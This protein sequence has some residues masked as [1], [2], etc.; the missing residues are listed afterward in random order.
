[1]DNPPSV[2]VSHAS[3]DK[4]RFVRGFA[5][6]LRDN[7]VD[8]WFDEWEIG[9]GD[10]LV[11]KIQE[12]IQGAPVGIAVLSRNSVTKP[13]VL[14]ELDALIVR[15]VAG[16]CRIIPIVLEDC[17]VP[18]LLRATHYIRIRNTAD[19]SE[20]LKQ[21]LHSLFGISNRPGI[22]APPPFADEGH[23]PINGLTRVDSIVLKYTCDAVLNERDLHIREEELLDH[24]R[25]LGIPDNEVSD[26]IVVLSEQGLIHL[27]A[28]EG[29]PHINGGHRWFE[30]TLHGFDM[31]ANAYVP[32]YQDA[33]AGVMGLIANEG[34]TQYNQL[35]ER[36]QLNPRLVVHILDVL[37]HN[38]YITLSKHSPDS[39]GNW[40]EVERVLPS[41]RRLMRGG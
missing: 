31:Y 32:N 33:V 17:E 3:E 28:W 21:I 40:I 27:P 6:E 9:P 5:R 20:E 15:R 38:G 37:E 41:L 23:D 25:P 2:F 12:G 26:S 29:N 10:S 19:Y 4:E 1:M 7:G 16:D 22:G 13:W 14:E 24:T 39:T 36:L 8:A 35:T 18:V 30:S 11:R 34:V